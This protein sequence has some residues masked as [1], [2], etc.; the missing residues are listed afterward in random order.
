MDASSPTARLLEELTA[1][2]E[3]AGIRM[4]TLTTLVFG[5]GR[6]ADVMVRPGWH[7]TENQLVRW[8]VWQILFDPTDHPL[9]RDQVRLF[10][11]LVA[12]CRRK[13]GTGI[14]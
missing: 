14:D 12:S 2:T 13:N 8:Q 6:V 9:N 10:H 3:V 5:S 11:Q 7:P 4:S 1:W